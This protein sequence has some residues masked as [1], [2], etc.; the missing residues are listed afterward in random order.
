MG[1]QA[2]QFVGKP[3]ADGVTEYRSRVT[4]RTYTVTLSSEGFVVSAEHM[5]PE[6]VASRYAAMKTIELDDLI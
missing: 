6:T 5:Q 3:L 4:G 2:N 1:M